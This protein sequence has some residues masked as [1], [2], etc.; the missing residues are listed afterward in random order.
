MAIEKIIEIKVKGSAAQ[1]DLDELN[2]TLEEQRS[3]LIELERELLQIQELREKTSKTN[4]AAQKKL[5]DQ[6]AHLKSAIKDQKLSLRELNAERRIS[7][8]ESKLLNEQ[9][10]ESS[11]I[12]QGL[13]KITGGYATKVKKLY[14]G[15]VESAKGVKLFIQGL[16]GLQKA[17]IATG[18]GALVVALGVVLAYWDDIKSAVSG[19]SS[20]TS[21]NLEKQTQLTEQT[22]RQY[23]NSKLQDNILKQQGM[24]EE[25]ILKYKKQQSEE[26]AKQLEAELL[27]TQQVQA[28]KA[29][30]AA[31]LAFSTQGISGLVGLGFDS[32]AAEKE[33]QAI[34]EAIAAL[35]NEYAGIQLSEEQLAKKADETRR[36]NALKRIQDSE[37]LRADILESERE[38][39]QIANDIFLQA[40]QDFFAKKI[41]QDQINFGVYRDMEDEMFDLDYQAQ[42]DQNNRKIEEE[43][44]YNEAVAA[45]R[46]ANADNIQATFSLL[47]QLA[48]KNKTLQAAALIG[49]NAAGIAKTIIQT[50]ASNAATIAQGNALSFVT[51]GAS[52]GIAAKLVAANKISAGISI[53]SSIA[54]TAKGLAALKASG[55]ASAGSSTVSGGGSASTPITP[56]PPSFNVVGASGTSQLADVIAKQ[57][58]K[59]MR[60]Y[61]VASDVSTAQSLERNIVKGASL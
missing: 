25:Q 50:Q 18:V 42:I 35:R 19:V 6:E 21:K 20:E 49:E 4:L 32:E 46:M 60:A 51:G 61:V 44:A 34:K 58:D 55:S 9:Q 22:K 24:S 12:I 28:Q 16:S 36:N 31:M 37:Q 56:T 23:E 17:L 40:S 29:A 10:L 54:A 53:A 11:K 47:G 38:G 15:F 14:E 33:I 1:K 48:G 13:D 57:T 39:E 59:P 7:T 41:E 8:N 2:A 45:I 27:V 3:I 26:Y 30:R 43:L 52:V 5:A